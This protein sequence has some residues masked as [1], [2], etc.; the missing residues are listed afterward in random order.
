[1]LLLFTTV[2]RKAQL[3]NSTLIKFIYWTLV[4]NICISI[5]FH[6]IKL[7]NSDGTTDTTRTTHFGTPT[8]E[9]KDAYTRVLLGN[10]DVERVSIP[11][12]GEYG[13]ADIDILA[14]RHLWKVLFI[15]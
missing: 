10:L 8:A 14:R 4:V 12:D 15:I 6:L 2:Q 11:S 3:Q 13:G 5:Y 7:Y 1:M 9:E